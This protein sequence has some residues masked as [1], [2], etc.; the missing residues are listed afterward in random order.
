MRQ[1]GLSRE[2]EVRWMMY[3]VGS[4]G[5]GVESATNRA[6]LSTPSRWALTNQMPR[7][8]ELP[9]KAGPTPDLVHAPHQTFFPID[10]RFSTALSSRET[11]FARSIIPNTRHSGNASQG[12]QRFKT[13]ALKTHRVLLPEVFHQPFSSH[14][15]CRRAT[16]PL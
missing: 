5:W 15:N 4:W 7:Y 10:A 14:V 3:V 11:A 13:G 12:I 1:S 9:H 16:R 6:S 8:L 2:S